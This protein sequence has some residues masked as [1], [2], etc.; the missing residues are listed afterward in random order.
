MYRYTG[1]ERCISA[2]TYAYISIHVLPAKVVNLGT[3]MYMSVHIYIFMH[4][5]YA[6]ILLIYVFVCVCVCV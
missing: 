1:I 2:Y 5:Q 6:Y 3:D 4:M